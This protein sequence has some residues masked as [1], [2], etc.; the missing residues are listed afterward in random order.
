MQI[1]FKANESLKYGARLKVVLLRADIFTQ[2]DTLSLWMKSLYLAVDR[3]VRVCV[4]TL[5][6]LC[7]R[8]RRS[9]GIL[10]C[11]IQLCFCI[12]LQAEAGLYCR[13]THHCPLLHY[14]YS[15]YVHVMV[16]T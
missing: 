5:T 6:Y 16:V 9:C 12:F 7:A 8:K 14:V 15:V 10:V 11:A 3:C 4:R 2:S 1:S 13:N